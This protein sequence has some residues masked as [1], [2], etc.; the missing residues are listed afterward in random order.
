[1]ADSFHGSV[2]RYHFR[3]KLKNLIPLDSQDA[4]LSSEIR[5]FLYFNLIEVVPDECVPARCFSVSNLVIL[6]H[7][8]SICR[9]FSKEPASAFRLKDVV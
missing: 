4:N 8:F 7:Q 3:L 6:G 2:I 5:G 1:M 9:L